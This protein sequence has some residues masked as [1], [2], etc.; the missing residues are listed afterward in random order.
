MRVVDRIVILHHALEP[1]AVFGLPKD[2]HLSSGTD[3]KSSQSVAGGVGRLKR[4]Q[5]ENP[6]ILGGWETRGYRYALVQPMRRAEA[7]HPHAT[8]HTTQ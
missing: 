8:G 1:C 7:S 3:S 2:A 6:T 5:T 4:E